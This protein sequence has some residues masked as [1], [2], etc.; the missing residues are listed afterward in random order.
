MPDLDSG[1]SRSITYLLDK[2]PI[3]QVVKPS[4]FQGG[5][6]SSILSWGTNIGV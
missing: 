2:S 4:P 5:D 3:R 6:E 1:V